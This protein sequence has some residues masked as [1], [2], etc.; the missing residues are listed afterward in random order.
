MNSVGENMLI[1]FVCYLKNDLNRL[2]N[3]PYDEVQ[4]TQQRTRSL[5]IKY[6]I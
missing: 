4:I 1:L 5:V 3:S 6:V 2:F